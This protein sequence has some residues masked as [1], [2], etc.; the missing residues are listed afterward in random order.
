MYK[1]CILAEHDPWE[2]RLLRVYAEK[3][4]YRVTSAYEGQEVM[5]LARQ[6]QPDVILLEENL[7]G[8]VDSKGVLHLLRTDRDTH[9]VPVIVFTWLGRPAARQAIPNADGYLKKP[10]TYEAFLA[11]LAEAGL[12]DQVAAER[13]GGER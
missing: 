13:R 6:E 8:A 4:G 1:T 9:D 12:G 3:I 11:A 5:P 10:A 7:P 2:I